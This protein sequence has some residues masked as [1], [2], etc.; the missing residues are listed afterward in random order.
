MGTTLNNSFNISQSTGA[1]NYSFGVSNVAQKGIVQATSMDKTALK[2]QAETKLG[3]AWKTGFS[4]NFVNTYIKKAPT[5]NDGV[6]ATVYAAPR[7][8]DLKGIPF[9]SPTDPYT[10]VLY[11]ATNFNNPYWGAKYNLFDERTN[12]FFGNGYV[13][14][15]P[16]IAGSHNEKL[17]IKYQ[18]GV[19]AFTTNLQDVNEYRSK[20]TLGSVSQY[21]V[22]TEIYNSLLTANFDMNIVEDLN[23]NIVA[24][25]EINHTNNKS[26]SET[27]T[28]F[29]F[30][31]WPHINNATT[32][33]ASESKSEYRTVGFFGNATLAY[34][35][36]LYLGGTGRY[37]V[38]SSMP[39]GNRGFFY[40]SVNLGIVLTELDA[41][42]ELPFLSFAKLRGSYAE[43]GQAGRY[44]D[45]YY[46]LPGY[47]GGFWT[48]NPIVYPIG[49]VTAYIPNTTQYDPN[50]KPQNT[51]SYEIG[52]E[53]KFFN[54]RIG[55]D[56]TFSRQDVKDQIFPVPLA[57]STGAGSLIMNGGKV[58]TTAHE[59]V[60]FFNPVHTANF[61]WSFNLNF[62]KMDNYVDE[63]APGVES[64]F[65]GGFVTPQ[66]RAGIGDKYP[67][68]YG[69]SFKRDANGHILVDE[70]ATLPNGSTNANYGFP[71]TGSPGV[72]G[73]ASPDFILGGSTKI[74]WKKLT[75]SATFD[76]KNGGQ[77]YSGTSGLLKYAYGLDLDTE[78]RTSKFIY[79]GYKAD[80]T[81][82]TIERGGTGD[83]A[84]LYQLR[85]NVLGNI[86]EAYIFES[87][88]VKMRE[89]SLSYR[90][91]KV[92]KSLNVNVTTFARN[93]LLWTNYPNFD[94]EASQGNNNMGGAFERF[95]VPQTKSFGLGLNIEF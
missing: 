67:V 69:T 5:A 31:G 65:L 46:V 88:F 87:S 51:V 85:A 81:P 49:G 76:W 2:L 45:N 24:G 29:N 1:M 6:L 28:N 23:L 63:L 44:M 72:I 41:V 68:I 58:H 21:G 89:L 60:L 84:A 16:S 25:N 50:L 7:N 80:G 4:G 86:D 11:R 20:N 10:Q 74:T 19:D 26:Y 57:G 48:G 95:S 71:L 33:D 12:R 15:A 61:D 32:K 90:F 78:D 17:V 54:N 9:S 35:N 92:Y 18:A 14:F 39:R 77:M 3:K 73:S 62:T 43:V 27:G 47:G 8:Y 42:K 93:I 37:D 91:V 55:I 13:E 40:P 53:L 79:P 52:T 83:L 94:P 64:I 75:A 59:V 22:S 36:F 70:R 30:G 34:K 82:S 56:Y 38:V 66:V